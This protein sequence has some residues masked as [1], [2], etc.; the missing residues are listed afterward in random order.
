LLKKIYSSKT[1]ISES[2][3]GQL[4]DAETWYF[5]KEAVDAGFADA[6]STKFA[7]PA[8]KVQANRY[9]N[10]PAALVDATKQFTRINDDRQA[11]IDSLLIEHGTIDDVSD[12]LTRVREE[13]CT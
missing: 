12:V 13:A 4:M 10:T 8:A 1:G 3:I 5:G 11:K 7:A 9:K 2:K 6:I